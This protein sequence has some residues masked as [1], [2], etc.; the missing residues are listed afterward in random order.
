MGDLLENPECSAQV[1]AIGYVGPAA[2]L[3]EAR[4]AMRSVKGCNRCICN[5]D[6]SASGS[7][8]GLADEYPTRRTGVTPFSVTSTRDRRPQVGG[9]NA[10][11]TARVKS[12]GRAFLTRQP[13]SKH[14]LL[15]DTLQAGKQLSM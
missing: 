14:C 8:H 6:G 4:A 2:D 11:T 9:G 5:K 10:A 15:G 12:T 7:S 1:S 3:G 13:L